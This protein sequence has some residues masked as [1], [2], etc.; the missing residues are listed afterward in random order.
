[1][2]SQGLG[3]G[4]GVGVGVGVGVED[5]LGRTIAKTSAYVS[6][7]LYWSNGM[8]QMS[9][10]AMLLQMRVR[11]WCCCSCCLEVGESRLMCLGRH[12]QALS[13]QLLQL[14]R[15]CKSQLTDEKMK[16]RPGWNRIE[17]R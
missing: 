17:W 5:F 1:M 16:S 3:L 15:T 8:G 9:A 10:D 2:R 4:A 11:W 14:G 12:K 13:P 6:L 7:D